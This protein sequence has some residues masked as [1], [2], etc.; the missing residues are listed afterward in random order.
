LLRRTRHEGWAA[1]DFVGIAV[2]ALALTAYAAALAVHGNGFVAAFSGGLAFG[3]TAG[4]RGPAELVFLEQASGLVSLLVWL[5]FGALTIST[6]AD[7][8]NLVLL[9][10]AILSLTLVRM[11]PVAV[12]LIGAGVDRAVRGLVRSTGL[13]SLVFALLALE[14]LGADADEAIAVIGLTVL[15][16]VLLSADPLA[17]RYGRA[18]TGHGPQPT[19][20][21]Q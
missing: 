16:S 11:V 7:R 2:L 15:L 10:Y 12:A 14:E 17:A 3:A 1:E 5:S 13:A 9:L 4:R 18:V 20:E 21:Q 19:P 8:A 6:I